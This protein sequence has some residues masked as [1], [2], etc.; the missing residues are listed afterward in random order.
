MV[1]ALAGLVRVSERDQG[2]M[3]KLVVS[4]GGAIVSLANAAGVR[5]MADPAA[6]RKRSL[7]VFTLTAYGTN[8][9]RRARRTISAM[10]VPA[11]S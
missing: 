5:R 7:P 8:S 1:L 3:A 2:S 10:A 4:S 9:P 6:C 11:L